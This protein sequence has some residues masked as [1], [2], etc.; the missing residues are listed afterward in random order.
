LSQYP[1][2]RTDGMLSLSFIVP[3]NRDPRVF[4]CVNSIS[5]FISFNH[6]NAEIIVCGEIENNS[7]LNYAQFYTVTPAHKGRCIQQGILNSK[8]DSVFIC[9]ADFPI[10]PEN[11][12]LMLSTLNH[13]DIV[14]GNRYL[15]KSTFII[16][17]PLYRRW[18]SRLFRYAVNKLFNF[19]NFDTQC[20]VKAGRRSIALVLFKEKLLDSY[21]YDIQIILRARQ[22]GARIRQVPVDWRS[23]R[24]S[25]IKLWKSLVPVIYELLLLR[26]NYSK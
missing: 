17:P 13:A 22:S 5:K 18:I 6:I 12:T 23:T 24:K 7:I 14:L 10:L 26:I 16:A 2:N 3:S 19:S 25:T 8:G 20:G 1:N 9:D 11:I 21:A 4:E 15:P